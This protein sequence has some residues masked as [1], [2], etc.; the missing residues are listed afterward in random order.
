[1]AGSS[2]HWLAVPSALRLVLGA[3]G[4][5]AYAALLAALSIPL[6][7]AGDGVLFPL[8]FTSPFGVGGLITWPLVGALLALGGR[9]CRV[10][11]WLMVVHYASG[12]TYFLLLPTSTDWTILMDP[13]LAPFAA[14]FV[15]G[16][17][18]IWFLASRCGRLKV[19]V[20]EH[21]PRPR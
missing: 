6:A 16:Q 9:A 4:G 7:G 11:M 15:F 13:V 21:L 5:L 10:A 2:T 12:L 20:G 18:L 1:M 17:V 19:K 14:A 3:A 8:A